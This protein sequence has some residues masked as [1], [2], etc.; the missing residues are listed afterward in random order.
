MLTNGAPGVT[1]FIL[2]CFGKFMLFAGMC[3]VQQTYT[4]SLAEGNLFYNCL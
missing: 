2:V 1:P 3:L 4:F